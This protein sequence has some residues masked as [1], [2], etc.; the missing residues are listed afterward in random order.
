MISLCFFITPKKAIAIDY[1]SGKKFGNEIKHGEQ[2]Q[3]YQLVTFLRYPELEEVTTELW[4]LDVD[5]ITSQTFT[6]AQG[7]R[8]QKAWERRG[9]AITTCLDF[10]PNPNVHSCRYCMLGTRAG[11]AGICQVGKW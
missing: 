11:G 3:L 2:L 1:K 5:E 4:Y 8:F 10:P 6:R 9:N 7:L